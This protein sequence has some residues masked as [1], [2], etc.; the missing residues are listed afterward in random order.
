MD[1]LSLGPI[2][3]RVRDALDQIAAEGVI[4]RVWRGDYT[5]WADN[6]SEITDPGRLGWLDVVDSMR[7]EVEGLQRFAEDVAAEGYTRAVL[8]GMGGSSLAPEV[9]QRMLGG[10]EGMLRL[11]VLDSTHPDTVLPLARELDRQRTL[12]LISSKSGTTVETRSHLEFFWGLVPEGRHFV[13]VTD[14]GTPLHRIGLERGFRRVFVNRSD[15]GGR[16][17]AL[18]HFGLV[19]AALLGGDPGALLESAGAMAAACRNADPREN[20]GAFLGAVLG[21]A[22]LAG[23]DKLTLISPED[24]AS[25]GDWV[26]QLIAESTGKNGKG[27]VPIIGEPPGPPEAYGKD[28]LFVAMGS[29]DAIKPLQAAGQPVVT[30]PR[31]SPQNLGAEMFRWEFATAI[32]AQRLG[33]H[34]FDQPDVQAAKDATAR[35]LEDG[36]REPPETAAI[37]ALLA[38]A[39]PGEYLAVLAFLPRTDAV[40]SS[41]QALR[42]RLARRYRLPVTLGFGPR[43]QH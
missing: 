27:I 43:Y 26:E 18:S 33:I 38:D 11:E 13:A 14:E 35:I 30:L 10:K 32:A 2:T 39:K 42:Q 3:T 40:E 19:P 36:A 12:F 6:P 24:T 9:F 1:A 20:P 22:A 25:F 41:L 16:Y 4:V 21:E 28:R 7:P 31:V 29:L 37:E 15:I 8:C 5:L 23:R 17:S 34:P